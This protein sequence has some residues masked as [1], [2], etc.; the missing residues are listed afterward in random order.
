MFGDP[1]LNVKSWPVLAFNDVGLLNR[2]ISKH[3]GRGMHPLLG[4]K[5]SH[6][7]N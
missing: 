2:G 3:K 4:M 6:N 5:I 1:V 7:S